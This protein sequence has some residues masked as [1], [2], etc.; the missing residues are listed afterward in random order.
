L[1]RQQKSRATHGRHAR[2][3]GITADTIIRF[4][5]IRFA[6]VFIIGLLDVPP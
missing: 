5:I 4:P 3:V 1:Q 2:A 6:S